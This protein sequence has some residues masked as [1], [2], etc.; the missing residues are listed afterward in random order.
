M[1]IQG[2]KGSQHPS[3]LENYAKFPHSLQNPA[4]NRNP[5]VWVSER[6]V[7]KRKCQSVACTAVSSVPPLPIFRQ[8][9]WHSLVLI[10]SVNDGVRHRI[11]SI[12]TGSLVK[13][14]A[15]EDV[16]SVLKSARVGPATHVPDDEIY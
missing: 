4:P 3:L 5:S 1:N 11:L 16:L 12:V 15:S 8:H 6:L 2:M 13:L 7:S 14:E 9:A 10:I